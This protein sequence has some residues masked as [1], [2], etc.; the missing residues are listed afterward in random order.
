MLCSNDSKWIQK[1]LEGEIAYPIA[2]D[3]DLNLRGTVL[4]SQTENVKFHE[5]FQGLMVRFERKKS[6]MI[7]DVTSMCPWDPGIDPQFKFIWTNARI[8]SLLFQAK[9]DEDYGLLSKHGLFEAI[10][11]IGEAFQEPLIIYLEPGSAT[12][13]TKLLSVHGLLF[14]FKLETGNVATGRDA[15]GHLWDHGINLQFRSPKVMT[16]WVLTVNDH[17]EGNI[18]AHIGH[19]VACFIPCQLFGAAL[20]EE[21]KHLAM[22][23][24]LIDLNMWAAIRARWQDVSV[25]CI[26]MWST[27]PVRQLWHQ[28]I[29]QSWDMNVQGF[30]FSPQAHTYKLH[31]GFQRNMVESK[32]RKATVIEELSLLHPWDPGIKDC[33]AIF[34]IERMA[35]NYADC[36]KTARWEYSTRPV[37]GWGSVK[38]KQKSTAGWL[39]A[40]PV[41]EPHWQVCMAGGLSTGWIEWDG[42]RYEFQNA[43]S[44]SEKNWGGAFPKKWFWVQCNVFEG[45]G[46]EVTLTAAGG[47]RELPG[48]SETYENAALIGVHYDGVFY[49]FVPWNG[50]VNWEIAQWGSWSMSAENETHKVELEATTSD[51]GTT[52]RAPTSEAGLAPACRDTC[53][54]NLSLRVWERRSD[55]SNGKVVLDVTS[56][57]AALE[58][59]GGP[60]FNTWKGKTDA[61]EFVKRALT[62]PID[63]ESIFG[64]VPLL[65]PPGL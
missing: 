45:A 3:Q 32:K 50:V 42:K 38:S 58:V 30:V 25:N 26:F 44:Y 43:P 7:E 11:V 62:L 52:L 22:K 4:S 19:F 61:P 24:S 31:K 6:L 39:A 29:Q 55:G 63:V 27:Q 5:Y 16:L 18:G 9:K 33:F 21:V 56:N 60:W 37:Y 46:G 34:C 54:G 64:L 53:Y 51:P 49:E 13:I 41:F 28:L 2:S 57:M 12:R 14:Y 59:G 36:V 15:Y 65:K 10:K 8:L 1:D 47:L 23:L 40:F 35:T 17:E 48:L 20:L